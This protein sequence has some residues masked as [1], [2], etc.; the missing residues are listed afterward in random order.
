MAEVEAFAEVGLDCPNGCHA[1]WLCA[2]KVTRYHPMRIVPSG[3]VE[4]EWWEDQS[5][6]KVE[7]VYQC[8][9]CSFTVDEADAELEGC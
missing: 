5:P 8:F 9:R 4:I 7:V 6:S 1:G 3:G 2:E